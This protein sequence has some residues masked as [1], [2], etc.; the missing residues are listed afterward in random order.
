[1]KVL[2]T[3]CKVIFV[4]FG[5][6]KICNIVFTFVGFCDKLKLLCLNVLS[7]IMRLQYTS[8]PSL[9]VCPSVCHVQAQNSK[10]K[11]R[12]FKIRIN[13]S[14]GTHKWCASFQ[15]KRS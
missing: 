13:I 5:I 9:S 12:K 2:I 10:T 1:M 3:I 14:Q 6:S 15:L 4:H 7:V 8:C 11:R